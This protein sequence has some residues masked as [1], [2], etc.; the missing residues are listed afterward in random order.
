MNETAACKTLAEGVALCRAVEKS[1]RTYML[2]ENYPY[3]AASQELR[4]LYHAGEAGDVRY[5]EGEYNHPG[6][7]NWRL[8]ISPGRRHWRT[9]ASCGN[10]TARTY[11][12]GREDLDILCRR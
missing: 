4:R 8:S 11:H 5:A 2:A 12:R 3:S 9:P 6:E 10:S 1:G 7:E